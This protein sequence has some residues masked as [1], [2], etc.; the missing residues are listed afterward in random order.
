MNTRD[1]ASGLGLG[2]AGLFLQ[3]VGYQAQQLDGSQDQSPHKGSLVRGALVCSVGS[4]FLLAGWAYFARAKGRSPA[5]CLL[6]FVSFLGLLV[7]GALKDLTP[8]EGPA[9]GPQD[10]GEKLVEQA[11]DLD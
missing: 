7:L 10:E 8:S 5:W 6:A 4:G 11:A 9:P 2:A 1:A 3:L